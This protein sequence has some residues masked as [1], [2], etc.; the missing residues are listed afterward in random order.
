MPNVRSW[1]ILLQKSKIEQ[2]QKS[3]ESRTLD[4]SAAASLL[5]A[6]T[7]VHNRFWMKRYGPSRRRARSASAALG[8]FVRHP[9]KTF[10]TISAQSR[11]A[12][13]L[14][15]CPLLGGTADMFWKCRYFRF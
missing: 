1:Q 14:D 12:A 5:H 4:F 8:I 2:P 10:A 11:R 3:R 15:E 9:K 13:R 7:E 6:T